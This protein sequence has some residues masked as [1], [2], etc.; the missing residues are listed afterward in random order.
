M[1]R[2]ENPFRLNKLHLVSSVG[3]ADSAHPSWPYWMLL[4]V[5]LGS[6]VVYLDAFA[7]RTRLVGW[8]GQNRL[9]RNRHLSSFTF[10][11]FNSD[12]EDQLE[13]QANLQQNVAFDRHE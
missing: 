1:V 9:W 3:N 10:V 6:A 13:L 5:A 8:F 2:T 7:V 12:N 4:F 11:R